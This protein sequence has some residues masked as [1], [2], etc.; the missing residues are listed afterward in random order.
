MKKSTSRVLIVDDLPVNRMILSSLL[1]SHGVVSDQAEGGLMCLEMAQKND[2]DLILMDHRMPDLDGVDTFT[3]LKG[4]FREK[5]RS[6]PVI[7]HTT[8]EGRA[9]INLY[10]AAGFADVLIKPIDPGQLSD[11]VMTYL[12]EEP[13]AVSACDTKE[14]VP[15]K[16]IT[17]D[18]SP[19]DEL[20][21]LPL[22][23]K[24]VPQ[25]DLKAGIK[26]C[27]SAE[28]YVDA[29][30]IFRSSIEE[31]ADEISRCLEADDWTGYRLG[32]HSLKSMARLVGARALGDL[33][34]SLEEC[35]ENKNIG[36]IRQDT[37]GLI[38]EYRRFISLLD[39]LMK[40]ESIKHI[41]EEAEISIEN[42]ISTADAED[43][44][45]SVLFVQTG[46]GIAAKGI[47]KNLTDNG[48]D[49]IT[50]PDSPDLIINHRFDA[51]II[52]Y[53]P[54]VRE[55]SHIGV[56]MS[57]LGEVCRDDSRI[58]CLMG[59]VSDIDAAMGSEGAYRVSRTYPRPVDAALFIN[60]MEYLSGLLVEYHRR[61]AV[62][63]VDDDADYRSVIERWLVPSYNVSVFSG[64]EEMLS[65]LGAV[66][67]DLILLDYEMPGMDGY[68]LM[69]TLRTDPDNAVIP[70]IFLTG[71]NDRDHVFSILHYKPDGYLLKSSPREALIDSID[72]FFA[73]TFFRRSLSNPEE[74]PE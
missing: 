46:R 42:S 69:K 44:S 6:I 48:Y 73:E 49:V 29:L 31:K 2:Y 70:I 55:D 1:A 30:Y 53:Y 12:P 71:M 19:E 32:V 8:E 65:G 61:K 24:I 68:E 33:A 3:R 21:R 40:D 67:P 20:D 43:H 37:P 58:L 26:S 66:T 15:A 11:M 62:F 4:I 52:I 23:L 14:D 51:D 25:I 35:A 5:G 28:D 60:D 34:A 64:A 9:N 22:W 47:K 45:R 57:L 7:C 18:I 72:R 36:K 56:T 63:V 27:G 38:S 16:E 17:G 13:E 50:V 74:N 54:E 41:L 39:P 59:N 10:K